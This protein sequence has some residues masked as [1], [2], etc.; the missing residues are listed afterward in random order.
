MRILS[1]FVAAVVAVSCFAVPAEAALRRTAR[2]SSS[3][4]FAKSTQV[5]LPFGLFT[6]LPGTWQVV[7]QAETRTK[8][9]SSVSTLIAEEWKRDDCGYQSIRRTAL[10]AWAK[11]IDPAGTK[12][13]L[14]PVKIENLTFNRSSYKGFRWQGFN[15]ETQQIEYRFCL[16]QSQDA[17][18]AIALESPDVALQQYVQWQLPAQLAV[19]TSRR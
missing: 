5:P 18:I 3:L 2:S 1:T 17:A 19:R 16:A 4:S 7:E 15:P 10:A 14:N 13:V 12:K 8:S 6:L 9:T 11:K